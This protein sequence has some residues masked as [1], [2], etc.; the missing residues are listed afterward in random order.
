MISKLL[1]FYLF[2]DKF[3][4]PTKGNDSTGNFYSAFVH[5]RMAARIKDI[6]PV[7]FAR[8]FRILV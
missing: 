7:Y 2:A 4:C 5:V 1:S 6:N 8:R 3:G